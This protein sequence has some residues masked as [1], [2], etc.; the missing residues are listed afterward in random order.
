VAYGRSRYIS[1][2]NVG[3][4]I[5]AERLMGGVDVYRHLML[6]IGWGC[7]AYWGSRC[8]SALNVGHW[9]GLSGL[10]GE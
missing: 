9:M 7:V 4:W 6:G 2:L 5:G 3:H 1:A 10:W 8:V